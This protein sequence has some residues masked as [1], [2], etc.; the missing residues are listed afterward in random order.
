[1]KHPYQRFFQLQV[2]MMILTVI[3]GIISLV[4]GS[5]L[6]ALLTC[7]TLA[8]SF[9]FEGMVEF[10]KQNTFPFAQQLLRAVIIIIFVSF[11]YFK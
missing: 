7:F 4:K 6:L 9:A 11:L 3:F 10:K 8:L 1:M 2:L 5:M